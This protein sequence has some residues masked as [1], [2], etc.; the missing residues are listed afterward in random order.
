VK[1][2]VQL[3]ATLA[4]YLPAGRPAERTLLDVPAGTRVTDLLSHLGIPAAM[5]RIVLVNGHD[6]DDDRVLQ[7]DD[8][9]SAF[10]PLA[11]GH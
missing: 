10:P 3:F 2:E 11:G 5:P 1:V 9:V 7:P 4:Q 8:V 6:A